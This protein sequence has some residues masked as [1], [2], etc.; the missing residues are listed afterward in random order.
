MKTL[1]TILLW[2]FIAWVALAMVVGL[3]RKIG[4]WLSGEASFSGDMERN[5]K[6]L[7]DRAARKAQQQRRR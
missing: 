7:L 1:G 3:F 2:V 5:G 4:A 6:Q